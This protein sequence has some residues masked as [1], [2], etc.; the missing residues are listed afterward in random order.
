M[1]AKMRDVDRLSV[2]QAGCSAPQVR[3]AVAAAL[4]AIQAGTS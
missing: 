3:Q 4:A 2:I 1:A